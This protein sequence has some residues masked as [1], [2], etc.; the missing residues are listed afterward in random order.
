MSGPPQDSSGGE[1]NPH[2]ERI[3]LEQVMIF[4]NLD[5]VISGP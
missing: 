2:L 4:C 5:P 1:T 3:L